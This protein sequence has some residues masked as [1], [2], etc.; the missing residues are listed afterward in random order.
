M[1][2]VLTFPW[3]GFVFGIR[4]R[5]RTNLD[6]IAIFAFSVTTQDFPHDILLCRRQNPEAPHI[7]VQRGEY[8]QDASESGEGVAVTFCE[9]RRAVRPEP[10]G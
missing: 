3:R 8:V 7:I 6:E 9:S 2:F 10:I 1:S 4:N 5:D